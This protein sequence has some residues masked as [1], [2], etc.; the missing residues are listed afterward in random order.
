MASFF[1]LKSILVSPV[2]RL[3]TS[4]RTTIDT[5]THILDV[6]K[7]TVDLAIEA[8]NEI[9]NFE[10]KPHWKIRAMSPQEAIDNFKEV[11]KIPSQIV[12][13]VR[14]LIARV[15]ASVAQF[16][17]PAAEAE[18]AV[19]EAEGLEGGFLRLFPRLASLLGKAITRILGIAALVVQVVIDIDNA[20]ADIHTIV[21]GLHD[22]IQKLNHLDVAFLKQTNPRRTVTLDDGTTMKI[23][24]GHLHS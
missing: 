10:L 17:S 20:V 19:A 6:V 5:A 9:K 1:N 3:I 24:V 4:I 13:A 2:S 11:A 7:E 23:R 22:V 21:K 16:R 14:D 12:I 8:Y 18:A 15:K